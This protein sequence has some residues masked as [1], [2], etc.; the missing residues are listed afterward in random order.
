MKAFDTKAPTSSADS[1]PKLPTLPANLRVTSVT[2]CTQPSIDSRT[3]APTLASAQPAA[4]NS[5]MTRT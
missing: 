2:S 5:C 4:A 1:G 3:T